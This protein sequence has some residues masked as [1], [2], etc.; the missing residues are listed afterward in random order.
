MAEFQDHS[1]HMCFHMKDEFTHMQKEYGLQ[2]HSPLPYYPDCTKDGK[3]VVSC[4]YFT[5]CLL[6]SIS[7]HVVNINSTATDNILQYHVEWDLTNSE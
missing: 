3:F 6:N 4:L 2:G 1:G 5:A 7:H